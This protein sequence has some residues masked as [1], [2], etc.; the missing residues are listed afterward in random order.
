MVELGASD[1]QTRAYLGE[2][3]QEAID[4]VDALREVEGSQRAELHEAS[5][6]RP[7]AADDAD[8]AAKVVK[9]EQSVA[10]T[11]AQLVDAVAARARARA[12]A[13]RHLPRRRGGGAA[14]PLLAAS[15]ARLLASAC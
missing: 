2:K 13:A 4:A 5:R 1:A 14:R 12:A 8:A 11:Q 10:A 3:R 7:G 6:L 15:E 9:L